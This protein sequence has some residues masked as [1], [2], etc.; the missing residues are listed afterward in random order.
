MT[1]DMNNVI[2]RSKVFYYCNAFN[3]GQMHA[4]FANKNLYP[5]M[6]YCKGNIFFTS[7]KEKQ[8]MQYNR[9]IFYEYKKNIKFNM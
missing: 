8:R 3:K 4:Y 6:I 7:F 5:L 2:L 1:V 9:R